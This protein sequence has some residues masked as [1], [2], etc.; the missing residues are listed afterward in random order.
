MCACLSSL[1]ISLYSNV[2]SSYLFL[3]VPRCCD[4]LLK[5]I[6][7]LIDAG[8]YFKKLTNMIKNIYDFNYIAIIIPL[9]FRLRNYG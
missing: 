3:P 4:Y 5:F 9:V 1:V 7:L 6:V 8:I 2:S